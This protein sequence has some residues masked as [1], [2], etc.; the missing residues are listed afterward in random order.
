MRCKY[1]EQ[2]R[3]D[4]SDTV[5]GLARFMAQ[6]REGHM[7]ALK[8]LIRY[9]KGKPRAY[10]KYSRQDAR[11][12]P[13]HNYN[14]SDW[15][16][17]LVDRKSTSGM[18]ILRGKHLLRHSSTLQSIQSLSSAEA[19]YYAMCRGAAHALG[20]QSYYRDLKLELPLYVHTDSSAGKSFAARRG[21]GKLRHVETRWLWLQERV[22]LKHLQLR[23]VPG[24]TSPADAMTKS[25][26]SQ[27]SKTLCESMGQYDR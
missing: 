27:R 16:G 13:I 3:M 2:D 8:R 5:K 14:D 9:L 7:I 25:L 23:K 20:T 18:V 1:L 22:A 6:P 24:E 4:I 26:T 11:N 12:A 21:L 17:D 15:A 19:E 10:L